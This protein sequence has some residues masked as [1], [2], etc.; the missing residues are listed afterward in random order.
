MAKKEP[1][2]AQE[3][4]SQVK[5]LDAHIFDLLEEKAE[6]VA[7]RE[8]ITSS[9]GTERVSG[10]EERDRLNET[11]HKI[12]EIERNINEKV[13]EAIKDAVKGIG[14]S[15]KGAV[16]LPEY[17][18]DVDGFTSDATW[19]GDKYVAVT[20]TA[21]DDLE[22]TAPA[23]LLVYDFSNGANKPRVKK[24]EF[25]HKWGHCNT[26]DYSSRNDCLIMGNGSGSYTLEGKI[27]I[28]PNFSALIAGG[29]TIGSES[30]PFTLENTNA[31]VIDCTGYG[32]GTKF[33]VMWGEINGTKH[34][35][36]YLI[37]A[38][39]GASTS[40]IDAGDNGTI[41][42]LLLGVGST[43]LEYG[44]FN[45]AAAPG[46]F[47]GTFEI[48][49]TYT[50]GGTA[51]PEC[52]Q[53]SCFYQGSIYAAI[54]HDGIWLWKMHMGDGNIFYDE[55]KQYFY[56]DDGSA[57]IACASSCCVKDGYLYLGGDIV[58]VMAFRL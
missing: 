3:Y 50:Q 25:F 24:T 33:N 40:A 23:R 21:S 29:S 51:Y 12:L 17:I 49:D 43:A 5:M 27:F 26:I 13:D 2:K 1:N 31:I 52:N 14:G 54:G 57:M 6:F 39:M 36:A 32:L 10:G 45:E 34:N 15:R 41:R 30:N 56:N 38:R 22:T 46:E 20:A 58:G 7:L 28:I 44:Q 19:V 37:T 4:L 11:T 16:G 48:L 8:K 55:W 47:N 42:R 9:W 53:G 35:I 18:L